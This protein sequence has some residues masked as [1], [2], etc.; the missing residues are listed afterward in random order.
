M[1]AIEPFFEG[2]WSWIRISKEEYDQ[3]KV[4]RTI[5]NNS[6][7]VNK[8]GQ[9]KKYWINTTKFQPSSY[10]FRPGRSIHGALLAIKHWNKNIA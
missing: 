1:N 8:K 4:D 7:K 5:P 6:I 9:F 10:G 3:L 2:S